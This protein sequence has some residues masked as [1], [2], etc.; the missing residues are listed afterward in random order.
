MPPSLARISVHLIFSTKNRQPF[1]R[2]LSLRSETHRVLGGI[3]KNLDCTPF[4]I[5]GTEDHVHFLFVLGR[6]R[7]VADVVKEL[8]RQ[9]TLWLKAKFPAMESFAWQS[10]YGAFSV[11]HSLEPAVQKY[12]AHQEEH[13][14]K[15]SF[16]E[17]FREFL[18]RHD[19]E[20]DEVTCGIDSTPSGLRRLFVRFPG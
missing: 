4:L 1:L 7:G 3:L 16:Q 11:S 13:H 6:A 15:V 18:K 10:G 9:S 2:E 12:I 5:N 17:E 14:R 19:I 20:F 8:K